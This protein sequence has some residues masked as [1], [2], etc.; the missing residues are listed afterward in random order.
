MASGVRRWLLGKSKSTPLSTMKRLKLCCLHRKLMP[1]RPFRKLAVCCQVISLGERLTR[2]LSM[3]WS[4]EKR[5]CAGLMSFGERVCCIMHI[6]LA[7]SSS[8]PSEPFGLVRL[9]ILSTTACSID[10]SALL[11]LKSITL[12]HFI[13]KRYFIFTGMPLTIR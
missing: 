12:Y 1:A 2:S 6:S 3:P 10:L 11:I 5:M 7:S 4:A 8:L 9:F 13:F